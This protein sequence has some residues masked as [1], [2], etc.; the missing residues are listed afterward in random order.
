MRRSS[1]NKKICI[2]TTHHS[3]LDDRIYYKEAR[4][5]QKAGFEVTLISP[6]N[7]DGFLTDMGG[8]PIAQGETVI[9]GIR[10][11][12]FRIG[13]HGI[14]GLPK[15]W[16]ISQ[17][18]RLST[19][20]WL[21]FRQD[22]FSEIINK[23]VQIDAHI[24]HCHEIWSLYAGVHIRHKLERQ[25]KNPKLIYDVHEFWSAMGSGRAIREALWSHIIDRFERRAAK[26]VDYFITVNHILRARLLLFNC[27]IKT[28]ILYNSPVLSIFK[29]HQ[30]KP[31][32]GKI[33]ICHEGSFSFNRGL[34]KMLEVMK[35]LKRRYD[36]NVRLLIVG[37]VFGEERNFYE[38]TIEEY[39]IEDVVECTGWLPYQQVGEALS[40]GHIGVT[41]VEPENRNYIFSSP[42]RLF[43][44]MRYGLPVV[45]IDY[46]EIRRIVINS[47]C[48]VLVK[49]A[50]IDALAHALSV[51]IDNP[52]LRQRLGKNGQAAIYEK[53]SWEKMEQKL[54]RVYEELISSDDYILA[55]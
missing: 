23:G 13:E 39:R 25:G 35:I 7:E 52:K 17:W 8:K 49:R 34:K 29:E 27:F 21:N 14:L 30:R 6:L 47:Q 37:D 44:Y 4:S 19:L 38:S 20:G 36:G 22:P 42:N 43:N 10:I 48:G 16:T 31:S 50:T 41:F 46:P 24:Y 54:L 32:D 9:D 15:T 18:L 53:Y 45:T 55:K 5:L 26:Y 40:D 2:L 51:L 12:G 1:M 33:T 28:E 3:A 11:I